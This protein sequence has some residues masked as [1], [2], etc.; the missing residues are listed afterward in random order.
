MSDMSPTFIVS[1]KQLTEARSI[2]ANPQ[3]DTSASLRLLAWAALKAER[4]QIV[5]Q[6]RVRQK[7]SHQIGRWCDE[8]AILAR[9]I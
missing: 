8:R 3:P 4:G 5:R 6:H 2:T 7:P 1:A 9:S